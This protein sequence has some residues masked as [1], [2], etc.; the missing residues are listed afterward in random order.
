MHKKNMDGENLEFAA[1]TL[2]CIG[3]GVIITDNNGKIIYLNHPSEEII[4][5]SANEVMGKDFDQVFKFL[6]DDTKMAIKNPIIINTIASDTI[7]GLKHNTIIVTEKGNSKYVSASCSPVKE[8]GSIIGVVVVLRD[9]TRLK[10]LEQE[11]INEKNNLKTIFNYAPVGMIMLDDNANIIQVND[12]ALLYINKKKEKVY[13]KHFGDS[14]GCT[15]SYKEKHGCGYETK[16]QYC[17]LR[18]AIKM[19]IQSGVETSNI[20]INK[21]LVVDKDIKN[22]WFRVSITP[23][24]ASGKRNTVLTLLDVTESKNKELNIIRA[25][26][27]CDNILNQIPSL[28]WKTNE[29]LECN[30]VNKMWKEFTGTTLE[31][32]SGYGWANVIHPEDLDRYISVRTH[33]MNTKIKESFQLEMRL[34][35]YDGEYRWCLMIGTPYYDLIGNYAGYIGSIYDI[36]D[37][38]ETEE[39]LIRYRKV[40]DNARDIIFFL[41]LDGNIIEANKT[42]IKA[43]GYTNEEWSSMNIRSIRNNWGYTEHQLEHANQNGIFFEAEHRRKDGSTFQVEVSSQGTYIGE[44]RIIFS[45]V[46]DITERKKAEKKILD[47]QIKYRSLFM[48]MKT[49]YAYYKLIYDGNHRPSNLK[50]IEVNDAFQKFFGLSKNDIL[51]KNHGDLFPKSKDILLE[52]INQFLN[53]LVEGKNVQIDEF[54]SNQYNKWFEIAIYS[55][56]ENDIVTIVT[57]ITHVKEAEKKLISAKDTAESA[58]KA[59]SEFLANMSHEIRTPING[60]VGMVDLTLLTEL[61]TEQKDN[62]ITAKACAN[63]LL[64]IINDVLDFSKMEAG[65]V[66]IENVNFNI[67]ELIEEVV[68]THSPR[69]AEKGLELN[70]TFSSTIPQFLIGDPNRLRQILNNLI[71]NAIKFT[72]RGSIDITIKNIA[73]SNDEVDLKFTVS[74]TGIGISSEDNERLFQSFSQ[75]ENSFTKKYAGS[76]LGLAISKNLI[77]LMGGRIGVESEI[78]KGSSFYFYLKFKLGYHIEE[79]VNWMPQIT[80][81][82]K[83]LKILLVEDDVVNQKVILKILLEKGHIIETANNGLEALEL[84]EKNK[85]DV[86]LMDIQMPRMDGVETNK[87]IKEIEKEHSIDHTPII[88]LTAYALHGDRER[89]LAFGFDD[90]IAKPIQMSELFYALDRIAEL[91]D[92]LNNLT[93]IQE[94]E[95]DD[96][97]FHNKKLVISDQLL[98]KNLTEISEDIKV[99]DSAMKNNNVMLIENMAHDIKLLS[100]E[101]DAIELKDTAFKI[102]LAARKGKLDEIGNYIEQIKSELRIFSEYNM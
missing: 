47:N 13:G 85:Y 9:I 72:E 32:V 35:R 59:K 42:A 60:I 7:I 34:L 27:Y 33:A 73:T 52:N 48:N 19:S 18:K 96:I 4:E 101:I 92:G 77:E 90:Y 63:S 23:I 12:A 46:R 88:A 30:Y 36:S 70:Y 62:L 44:Q 22:Y 37:R 87:K 94:L 56:K 53:K 43:Y 29:R 26:E 10:T 93:L 40:I 31:E 14:F 38:K 75:L 45:V 66:S 1:A 99:I 79:K 100:I 2:S 64:K 3:D 74:D 8:G 98:S 84:F 78:E 91:K 5:L 21:T 86:I 20:E 65:K 69:I 80:R 49:G 58:N 24:I 25:K 83:Q 102:E 95:N 54:F 11:H 67:K 89:F 71:S 16:C 41:D 61:S 76:G 51:G 39:E 28:V 17:D 57:D 68:K 50:F 15:N 55:P 6:E 82:V 81:P 97:L